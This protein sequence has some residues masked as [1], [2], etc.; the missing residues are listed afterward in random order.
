MACFRVHLGSLNF[1]FSDINGKFIFLKPVCQ[2]VDFFFLF[3]KD[4]W[5][6]EYINSWWMVNVS[7]LLFFCGKV[8]QV[9]DF[10]FF[11]LKK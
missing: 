2:G 5:K 10:A 7:F 8:I 6:P 11:K 9:F 1:F 3:L 4:F